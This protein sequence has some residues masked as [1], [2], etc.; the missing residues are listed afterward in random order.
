MSFLN[1]CPTISGEKLFAVLGSVNEPSDDFKTDAKFDE[2]LT[3]ERSS[4]STIDIKITN[5]IPLLFQGKDRNEL[6]D[7]DKRVPVQFI[8]EKEG[9]KPHEADSYPE[10]KTVEEELCVKIAYTKHKLRFLEAQ[11]YLINQYIHNI[12]NNYHLF[13]DDNRTKVMAIIGL[14][15]SKSLNDELVKNCDNPVIDL[16]ADIDTVLSESKFYL[17]T[18]RRG[19]Y[20]YE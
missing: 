13:D 6:Y 17:N 15:P 5:N 1:H 10:I 7:T 9:K 19:H 4:K 2:L 20:N 3:A 11:N 18:L 16:I 8:G 14:D 12:I